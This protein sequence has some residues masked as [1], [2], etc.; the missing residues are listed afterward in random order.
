[1]IVRSTQQGIV[2]LLAVIVV[3]VVV[4]AALAASI[5]MTGR[6][7]IA[8]DVADS[9]TAIIAADAAM[10]NA[11]FRIR[12]IGELSG[13]RITTE[14]ALSNGAVAWSEFE[15]LDPASPLFP[16]PIPTACGNRVLCI[17]AFGEFRGVRRAFEVSY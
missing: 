9:S 4:L 11:L 13:D 15:V 1:M 6:F 14:F 3:G 12:R 10:E 2:L 7:R 5:L 8:T 16:G 17:R